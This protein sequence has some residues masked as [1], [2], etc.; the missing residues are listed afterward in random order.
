MNKLLVICGPTAV[1]KTGLAI[2]L[3][4]TFGG[5][6]ISADSRQVFKRMDIGTGKDLPVNVKCQ[7][8]N[9]KCG[10]KKICFYRVSGVRIWGYDLIEPGEEFSVVEYIKIARLVIKD[11]WSRK[12]I[13]ILVG[14]TGF[15][16]KG[17]VDGIPT[18]GVARDDDL[19][20]ALE[21]K[22][23]GELFEM[24]RG[25]DPI[26]AASL[27]ASDRKNSRR[28]IRAIEVAYH[29]KRGGVFAKDRFVKKEDS[30]LFIGLRV[31]REIID[32]RIKGRLE[33]RVKQ[34]IESEIRSLLSWGVSW[35]S[36]SMSSLGYR[37][38]K[39]YFAG[40]AT[41]EKVVGEWVKQERSYVRR[42]MTWFKP[43]RRIAWFDMSE[44]GA[45]MRIENVVKEWH[46]LNDS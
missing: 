15:Y 2:H 40:E 10:R 5:E 43:D 22:D 21:G 30:V 42:Q 27:N 23:I 13:P 16:I 4:S 33:K 19:R 26:K 8:S 3:A 37:Q 35:D 36:Q 12:K 34:G 11:I 20:K 28:L 38:W 39:S 29:K 18:A 9:V 6:L 1:G 24:L 41:K 44:P 17:L 46:N 32:R 31:P 25:I 45:K 14:G 7:I